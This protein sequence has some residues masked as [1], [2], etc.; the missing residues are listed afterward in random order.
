MKQKLKTIYLLTTMLLVGI[1]LFSCSLQ[2]EEL[3]QFDHNKDLLITRKKVT[4]LFKEKRFISSYQKLPKRKF[5]V[6]NTFGRTVME[7]QY[8]FT[9]TSEYAN[10]VLSDSITS[11]TLSIKRDTITPTNNIENLVIQV[12]NYTEETKAFILKYKSETPIISF[13]TFTGK[14]QIIP[15]VYNNRPY[16]SA[17]SRV[18]ICWNILMP[19]TNPNTESH[20]AG[21]DSCAGA[22]SSQYC[23][24][25]SEGTGGTDNDPNTDLGDVIMT[26]TSEENTGSSGSTTSPT[27]TTNTTTATE[28]HNTEILTVPAMS[29]AEQP[30]PC[31]SLKKKFANPLQADIKNR[32]NALNTPTI[33]NKTHESG[34]GVT[35]DP[36]D[37]LNPVKYPILL[38]DGRNAVNI[39]GVGAYFS[40]HAHNNDYTDP[41][42]GELVHTIKIPS[43]GDFTGLI[44]DHARN[45]TNLG[46]PL[47]EVGVII[48]TSQGTYALML[49]NFDTASFNAI[50]G[51][52]ASPIKLAEFKSKYLK[53]VD[54]KKEDGVLTATFLEKMLL[55]N[56]KKSNITG[57]VGLYKATNGDHTAW[58]KLSIDN[59]TNQVIPT[60]CN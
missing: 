47:S 43:P 48:V 32:T 24:V 34:F 57:R 18:L 21:T 31:N 7:E 52:N 60:P 30:D 33:L 2:E 11:Y 39:Q 54:E 15:I 38:P 14:A 23:F 51:P 20:Q 58:A 55:N 44:K 35:I 45:A 17:T 56:M 5:T 4:K 50:F 19:C 26:P 28:N 1:T 59:R 25:F 37:Q 42:T 49:E 27:E 40:V 12:N 16:T 13:S 10:E 8:G 29:D 9:I 22:T 3:Q 41:I 6:V 36:N 46:L 53:D